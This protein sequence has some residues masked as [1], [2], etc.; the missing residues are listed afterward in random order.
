MLA[1]E[2][3]MLHKEID[4]LIKWNLFKRKFIGVHGVAMDEEQA[5]HF[6]HWFGAP[7]SNYFLLNNTAA[8]SRIKNKN[9]DS[10]WN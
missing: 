2:P 1:K 6:K 10:F 7:H 5:Q 9:T 3:I 8:Y 4:T